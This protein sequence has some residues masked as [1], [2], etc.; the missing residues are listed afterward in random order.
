VKSKNIALFK[1]FAK[2]GMDYDEAKSMTNIY[3]KNVFMD[4]TKGI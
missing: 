1:D 4:L 3:N 2:F